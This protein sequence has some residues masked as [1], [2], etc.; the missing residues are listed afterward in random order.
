MIGTACGLGITGSGWVA[1]PGVVVTAAHVVAGEQHTSVLL[2]QGNRRFAAQAIA[3]DS[4]NDVA[5]LRVP[6]LP[7]RPLPTTAPVEGATVAIVGYPL[8]GPLDIEAGTAGRTA[9]ILTD[10][11]Y[12]HGPV[13]RTVTSLGGK[14]RHG[15][16]G[17]PAID[18]QGRVQMTVFAARVSGGG[19]YGIPTSVVRKVLATAHDPISTGACAP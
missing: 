4:K 13:S 18:A 1:A 2:S 10:D 11:A 3:F 19:G 15:N 16:S 6:N 7:S 5:V 17:G 9:T 8:N 14:V 12:G